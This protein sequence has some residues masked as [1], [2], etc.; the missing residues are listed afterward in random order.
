[1][2]AIANQ[3]VI[4][5]FT[6]SDTNQRL[7]EI[8]EKLA[9]LKSYK[10]KSY[11]ELTD[12]EK[13]EVDKQVAELGLQ[14]EELLTRELFKVDLQSDKDRA[15]EIITNKGETIIEVTQDVKN[16]NMDEMPHPF[17][18]VP[19]EVVKTVLLD[20]V[21]DLSHDILEMHNQGVNV[22]ELLHDD[23]FVVDNAP[24]NRKGPAGLMIPKFRWKNTV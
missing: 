6:K 9:A 10:G 15:L 22:A 18:E 13:E 3:A 12:K 23:Y 11:E 2:P 14:A 20:P 7:G 1:M 16:I 8:A 5:P 24:S 19:T 4:Q 17:Y 21:C